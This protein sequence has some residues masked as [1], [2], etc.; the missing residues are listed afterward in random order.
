MTLKGEDEP[1]SFGGVKTRRCPEVAGFLF[2]PQRLNKSTK[3]RDAPLKKDDIVIVKVTFWKDYNPD[4]DKYAREIESF[5]QE[6][7]VTFPPEPEE[8][9]EVEAT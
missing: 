7:E 5:E 8:P 6:V 4:K 9:E 2:R 1:F 3:K